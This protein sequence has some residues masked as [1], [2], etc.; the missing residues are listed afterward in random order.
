MGDKATCT[1]H[2]IATN[3]GQHLP[4]EVQNGERYS[5]SSSP[6]APGGRSAHWL[7]CINAM[8]CVNAI[9]VGRLDKPAGEWASVSSSGKRT[10]AGAADRRQ[11]YFACAF[12][13]AAQYLFIRAET[14]FL[15]AAD[16]PLRRRR[17]GTD[18]TPDAVAPLVAGK[19]RRRMSGN[20]W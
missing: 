4:G 10:V 2:M 6:T 7:P 9:G 14:A 8:S 1:P 13:L 11:R 12:R 17:P 3:R 20:T 18:S 19:R 5:G 16:I 15:C